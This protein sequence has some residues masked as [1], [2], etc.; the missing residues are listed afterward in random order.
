MAWAACRRL[1]QDMYRAN[2]L[3]LLASIDVTPVE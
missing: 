2:A 1:G 3:R